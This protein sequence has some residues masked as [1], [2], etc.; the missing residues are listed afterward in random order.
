[1]VAVEQWPTQGSGQYSG[2]IS[3]L[4]SKRPDII[5]TSLVGTDLEAFLTQMAP[6]GL[7]EQSKILAAA[8]EPAM[9][10]M[11]RK[12]PDGIVFTARGTNGVFAPPSPLNDWFTSTYRTR[13]AEPPVYTAYQYANT[14]L[15]LKTAYDAA[16]KTGG[17]S[18]TPEVIKAL[19][20]ATFDT[21]SG[22]LTMA[23][24][25][26]HQAIL[27]TAVGEIVFDAAKGAP[28]VRN[29]MRFPAKCVNPPEG[30]KSESWLKD[31]MPGAQ[32]TGIV[33]SN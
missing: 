3:S 9:F 10:R 21:P 26:G 15:V 1:Q 5:H 14:L 2:E 17:K 18:T 32:C 23:L 27:D 16:T 20:G 24:G 31:G 28:S 33:S 8:L 13:H 30:V 29:A 4:A 7:H 6:R 19:T 12:I 25:G 22:K 11:G